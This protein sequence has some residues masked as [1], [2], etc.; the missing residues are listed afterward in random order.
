[1]SLRAPCPFCS[2]NNWDEFPKLVTFMTTDGE[3]TSMGGGPTAK[4]VLCKSCGF[5][6]LE[7]A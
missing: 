6:K 3:K 1:M 2:Q 7:T 5:F 4:A